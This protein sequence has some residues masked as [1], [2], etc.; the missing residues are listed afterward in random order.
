MNLLSKCGENGSGGIT[1]LKAG[2]E[3]MCEKILLRTFSVGVQCVVK[4]YLKFGGQCG[5]RLGMRHESESRDR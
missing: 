5:G 2:G 4:N 1:G 3:W